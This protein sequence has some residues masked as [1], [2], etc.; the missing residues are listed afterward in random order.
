MT[1]EEWAEMDEDEPGEL[2]GGFLEKEE[3]PTFLH[4]VVV[5]WLLRAIGLWLGPL[6]GWV[7]P[8]EHK[9]GVAADRG[10]KPDITIY[11]PGAPRP[12]TADSIGRQP[13]S[14]VIEVISPRPRDGRRDRIDKRRDY[15][16]F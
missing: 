13:P 15:A 6:G 3:V 8:S 16:A 7:L 14:A 2:V 4:E 10:R 12:R 5:S 9:L 1:L 11:L